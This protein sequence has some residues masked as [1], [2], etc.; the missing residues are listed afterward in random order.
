M[1]E[2]GSNQ[3]DHF[4][5]SAIL[6]ELNPELKP[7]LAPFYSPVEFGPNPYK[8]NPKWTRDSGIKGMGH[9]RVKFLVLRENLQK[10][11]KFDSNHSSIQWY[12]SIPFQRVYNDL[13]RLTSSKVME[14]IRKLSNALKVAATD[15][16]FR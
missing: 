3:L 2:R 4:L 9:F 13:N 15:S 1:L 10:M 11:G 8:K 16:E 5:N 12:W 14:D 7:R 6:T